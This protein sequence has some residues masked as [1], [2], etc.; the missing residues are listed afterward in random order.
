MPIGRMNRE[1]FFGQLATLDQQRLKQALW[2]L[3]WRGSAAMRER[4]EAEIDPDQRDRGK[5]CSKEPADPHQLL[6]EVRGFVAWR[7]RVRTWPVITAERYLRLFVGRAH[8]PPPGSVLA[9][10]TPPSVHAL[11]RGRDGEGK[12]G[13][14]PTTYA[15]DAAPEVAG[16]RPAAG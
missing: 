3:Y 11:G 6:G 15:A 13:A 9:R 2:N 16:T 14:C 10:R 4:I 8:P 12:P 5:R 7:A 1:Q